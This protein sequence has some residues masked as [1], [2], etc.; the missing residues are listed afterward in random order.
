M[1][2]PLPNSLWPVTKELECN[3]I[4]STNISSIKQ[5]YVSGWRDSLMMEILTMVGGCAYTWG[6]LTKN[7]FGWL[8]SLRLKLASNDCVFL[9]SVD[10]KTE[11][12]KR[13]TLII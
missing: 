7:D 12:C 8:S 11:K 1:S 9:D 2:A 10:F 3:V 6:K 4:L 5:T 13:A